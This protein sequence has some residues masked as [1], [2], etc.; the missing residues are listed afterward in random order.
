MAIDPVP[1]NVCVQYVAGSHK[2]GW[3]YPV[4]FETLLPYKIV[5]PD[6]VDRNYEPVPDID[7]NIDKYKI[8]S[9]DMQVMSAFSL[10]YMFLLIT[11]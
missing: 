2:W 3:Y 10:K 4:K 1:K 5:K 11:D 9:W 6:C 7:A 8:L